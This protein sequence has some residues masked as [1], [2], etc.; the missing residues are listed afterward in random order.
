M[1][2]QSYYMPG[3][4]Q[5]D[6]PGFFIAANDHEILHQVNQLINRQGMVGLMDTAGRVHYVIDGRRGPPFA[7]RR[8]LEASQRILRDRLLDSEDFQPLRH[9]AVEQV[10]TNWQIPTQLKGYR[11]LRFM[12]QLAAGND[13]E[14]K[15]VSKTLYPAAA[16][17][18]KVGIRQIERDIRYALGQRPAPALP[19]SNTAAICRLSD[20]VIKLVELWLQKQK[21]PIV[22]ESAA[23]GYAGE[24][25][26][27]SH[28]QPGH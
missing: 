26:T 28:L 7:A 3:A 14:L 5:A 19:T 17:A 13:A 20:E 1:S 12:L 2:Q 18:F 23:E 9:L 16:D 8:I 11:Y 25:R 15:P 22:A 27:A 21:P 6:Q 4:F 24:N 10:L